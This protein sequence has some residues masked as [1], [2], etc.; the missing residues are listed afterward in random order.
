MKSNIDRLIP[1][2]ALLFFL[3]SAAHAAVSV[4]LNAPHGLQ[5]TVIEATVEVSTDSPLAGFNAEIV[6]PDGISIENVS[7]GN[8]LLGSGN[9][10]L[11]YNINGQNLRVIAHAGFD[12]FNGTGKILN[13]FLRIDA[14]QLGLQELSFATVNPDPSINSRHAV[15][16]DDGSVSLAHAVADISFLAYSVSSDFD[17]DGMPDAWEVNNGLDPQLDNSSDDSD[18][19]GYSDFE[20]YTEGTDPNDPG[21]NPGVIFGDS[22]ESGTGS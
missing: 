1:C 15:S 18:K 17:L 9:F 16:N 19:D 4:T 12:S 7:I 22:F 6:F 13:L 14:A 10:K 3:S 5:G 2:V 8:L 11:A 21:S 20:E